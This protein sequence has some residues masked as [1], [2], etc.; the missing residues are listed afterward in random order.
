MSGHGFMT[1]YMTSCSVEIGGFAIYRSWVSF[2]AIYYLTFVYSLHTGYVVFVNI[3]ES[4]MIAQGQGRTRSSYA[5]RRFRCLFSVTPNWNF[6]Y[7]EPLD[8]C[9]E[10]NE[11]QLRNQRLRFD[12]L[13]PVMCQCQQRSS[14]VIWGHWSRMTWNDQLFPWDWFQSVLEHLT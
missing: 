11:C 1:S 7:S 9:L 12:F 5:R 2:L 10:Q 13:R 8:N 6:S 3:K 14:E 4:Y